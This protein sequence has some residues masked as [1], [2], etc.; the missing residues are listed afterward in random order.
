MQTQLNSAQV[1]EQFQSQHAAKLVFSVRNQSCPNNSCEFFEKLCAGNVTVHAKNYQ[2]FMCKECKRTW[3]AHRN[4]VTYRLHST[5]QTFQSGLLLL[6]QGQSV[7]AIARALGI[8][9]STVQRWKSKNV[10]VAATH[11]P[12]AFAVR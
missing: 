1:L 9:P 8:S 11:R 2:R 4:D 5:P 12:L 10:V 6:R 3:V 7:R